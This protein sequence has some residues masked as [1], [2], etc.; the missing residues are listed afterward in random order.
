MRIYVPQTVWILLILPHL[1]GKCQSQRRKNFLNIIEIRSPPLTNVQ[2]QAEMIQK[3][4]WNQET[5]APPLH[6]NVQTQ[7]EKFPKKV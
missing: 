7:A 3:K 1:I 6:E 4:V 5:P 2:T